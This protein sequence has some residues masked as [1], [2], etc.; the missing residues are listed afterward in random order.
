ME[1][2][3]YRKIKMEIESDVLESGES[4][5]LGTF[6][7]IAESAEEIDKL[8]APLMENFNDGE[9]TDSAKWFV[10]GIE[11]GKIDKKYVLFFAASGFS[12]MFQHWLWR[13]WKSDTFMELPAR[14]AENDSEEEGE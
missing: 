14:T 6:F 8:F 11:S 3:T 5:Y 1:G 13:R 7:N 2:R 10:N 4:D 12:T 9:E